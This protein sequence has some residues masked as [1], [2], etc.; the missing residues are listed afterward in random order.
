M[1]LWKAL[2]LTPP[3]REIGIVLKLNSSMVVF[4][5][6]KIMGL[7][8]LDVKKDLGFQITKYFDGATIFNDEPM[9]I[10]NPVKLYG[11]KI[12]KLGK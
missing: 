6:P 9:I 1:R 5:I 7:Y 10:I 2:K 3:P 12:E 8:D 4:S 11:K